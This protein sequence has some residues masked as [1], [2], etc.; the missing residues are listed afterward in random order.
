MPRER[1]RG[2]TPVPPHEGDQG[3]VAAAVAAYVD[4]VVA[5]LDGSR[6]LEL[7]ADQ[8]TGPSQR[9]AV[10]FIAWCPELLEPSHLPGRPGPAAGR[11]GFPEGLSEFRHLPT[12]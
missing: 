1:Q 6:K 12:R 2:Q 10:V 9:I 7:R 4:L 11:R 8:V 5:Q 3:A